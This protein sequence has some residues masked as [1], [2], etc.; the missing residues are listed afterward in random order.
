MT[1]Y[2]NTWERGDKAS[3]ELPRG[4]YPKFVLIQSAYMGCPNK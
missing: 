2:N 1:V 3:H 4:N